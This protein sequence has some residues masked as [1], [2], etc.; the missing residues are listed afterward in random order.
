MNVWYHLSTIFNQ[1][2]ALRIVGL[3]TLCVALTTTLLLSVVTRAAPGTNQTIAFQG[4]LQYASGGVVADGHYNIQFKIYQDG[5]GTAAGNPGGTLKWTESHVNDGTNA[6]IEVKGG[7]FSVNLG[8]ENPFGTSVDWNQD[9][10]WLS[11]NIAGSSNSCTTFGSGPCTADGE[12]LPM[13]RMTSTPYAMNA[14]ALAGKTADNFVQLAQGVQSDASTNTS[15]IHINKTGTGNLVQL[16]SAGA[17]VFT[18]EN[19]GDL[20]FGSSTNKTISIATA[21]SG[22][23]GKR[24]RIFAGDGGSG[25]GSTGGN[26]QLQGGWAGGT[27]GDGGNVNIDAGAKSGTGFDGY[28]S[29]GTSHTSAV[30]IGS[31][32]EALSQ[33]IHLGSNNTAGSNTNVYIGSGG[34][35]A[36]GTTKIQSKDDTTISTNGEQRA[37]FSSEGNTLYLGNADGDGEA[38]TANGFTIQGTSSTGVDTQGG[39]LILQAGSAI[40]GN[41]N[42]GNLILNGGAGSG[43]GTTGLVVITT[44]TFQ[45]SSS[46]VNCYTN[47]A[48]VASSCTF[49]N[50]S[51]NGSAVLIAGFSANGQVATLPDPGINTAGRIMY[52]TAANGSKEFTLRAN[53]G[54]GIGVEQNITMRQNTTAT[55]V[56]NGSDWTSAGGSNST[57]L[58]D[59]YNNS[60]QNTG[61]PEFMVAS[62]TTANGLTVRDNSA[63][64]VSGTL[65]EV[66][67][68]SAANLFSVNSTTEY[69]S[70]GGAETA[71]SNAT[72]IADNTWGAANA[73]IT[74][75][76]GSSTYVA[77]GQASAKVM[78]SVQYGGIYNAL[79]APLAPSTTYNVSFLVRLESGTFND[80]G[81]LYLSDGITPTVSCVNGMSVSTSEWTKVNCT[82]QTPASGITA[83]NVVTI[84]QLNNSGAHAYYI[85]NFSVT[86]AS[87]TANVQV[88]SGANGGG[89]TTLFTLDKSASAPT[90][91]SNDALLGSMYYDTTIGKLQCYEADGWGACGAAPD[92]FI[93]LSPEY[94]GAVMNGTGI[95]TMS[96][97]LCSDTLNINDGSSA[98]P[99]VCGTNETFNFYNWTSEETSAQTK[100]IYVTYQLP[101]TFKNFVSGA[102]SLMGRT[103]STDSNVNYQIY[104]NNSTS[105]LTACG[106]AIE[107]STGVKTTWQ[108]ANASGSADPSTCDFDAGDSIV[109][110]INLSADTDANA[111]VSNLNFVFSSN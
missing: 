80:L 57:T 51:V 96:S 97:D 85:D 72:I 109:F 52:V 19:T 7:Y 53:A 16:Q 108:K 31:N 8:E 68:S 105:G 4:R 67:T 59:A 81:V 77:S 20:T 74:R 9:T 30:F 75:H 101:A 106:S 91:A 12:M 32:S 38:E 40:N 33:E 94:S 61:D 42:G 65:L 6:G 22:E 83:S 25:S 58:Q 3:L 48:V 60:A 66:Q 1:R 76:T 39:M 41:A 89:Q 5:A 10:L 84:G 36:S 88:G 78:S 110:R 2:R 21:A 71:G 64:S 93:T 82:F 37:R 15:S 111:Y 44:P 14:G 86:A 87:G 24:L 50:A 79:R 27:N 92:T 29:I 23:D 62:N 43:S 18:V 34:D 45:T 95:G 73:T 55:M 49:T 99:T 54:A 13:Q 63:N 107:T 104:R 69:A 56:W 46:D 11:M 102:T 100:S 17:D 103:D 35:A 90:A 26:L 70:N 47:G 98:Q 28:I